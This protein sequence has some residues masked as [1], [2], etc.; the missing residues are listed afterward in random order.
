MPH[1]FRFGVLGVQSSEF[2]GWELS[3]AFQGLESRVGLLAGVHG[4]QGSGFRVW[5]LGPKP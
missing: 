3:V 4:L 2:N 1:Q 5:G